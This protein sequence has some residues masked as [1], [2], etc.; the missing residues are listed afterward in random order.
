[1]LRSKGF[2]GTRFCKIKERNND[3]GPP[4]VVVMRDWW[5]KVYTTMVENVLMFLFCSISV[6]ANFISTSFGMSSK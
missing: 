5:G 1:M 3:A 4:S 6:I 2:L